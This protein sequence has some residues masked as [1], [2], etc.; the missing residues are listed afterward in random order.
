MTKQSLNRLFVFVLGDKKGREAVLEVVE[1]ESLTWFK[2]DAKRRHPWIPSSNKGENAIARRKSRCNVGR[3]EPEAI[4]Y[5]RKDVK[6]R[7]WKYPG[8]G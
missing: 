1:S 7:F 4:L 5:A 8:V 2:Q 6:S 3:I